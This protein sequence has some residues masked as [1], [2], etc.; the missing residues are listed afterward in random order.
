MD[1]LYG[2]DEVIVLNPR[3][4]LEAFLLSTVYDDGVKERI[5]EYC[6]KLWDGNAPDE[7]KQFF[8]LSRTNQIQL[9]HLPR[10]PTN[11]AFR[12]Y[13]RL[14]DLLDSNKTI[15]QIDGAQ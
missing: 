2:L 14:A 12:A 6:S 10:P 8:V 7:E 5:G 11:N 4:D 3:Q 15:V 13:Y 9:K 1:K